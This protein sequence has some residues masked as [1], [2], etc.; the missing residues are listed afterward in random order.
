M[1][2][3]KHIY[4]EA[5]DAYERYE[6]EVFAPDKTPLTDEH[7]EMFITGYIQCIFDRAREQNKERDANVSD[8]K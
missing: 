7:R 2:V 5:M 8:T 6:A 1:G 3:M 4:I